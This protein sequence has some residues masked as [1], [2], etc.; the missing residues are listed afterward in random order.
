MGNLICFYVKAF[1]KEFI[2]RNAKPR[3]KLQLNFRL[4]YKSMII[5]LFANNIGKNKLGQKI[6]H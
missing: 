1:R 2:L 5:T 6:V 4:T 3:E